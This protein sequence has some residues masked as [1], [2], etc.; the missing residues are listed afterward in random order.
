M[1]DF[2][3]SSFTVGANISLESYVG[4]VGAAWTIAPTYTSKLRVLAS[5]N[6]LIRNVSGTGSTAYY[7]SGVSSNE[8]D[9]SAPIVY[10]GTGNDKVSM[11]IAGRMSTAVATFYM[12]RHDRNSN[13]WQLYKS[14]LGAFTLLGSYS[15]TLTSGVETA[16]YSLSA[17]GDLL[18]DVGHTCIQIKKHVL[19]SADDKW[20]LGRR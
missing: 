9:V 14:V 15:Q 20:R 11:G 18:I 2:V 17:G 13:T 1:G 6:Q 12:A 8:Y 10:L 19:G 7:A 5:G 16:K 4:E 3:V